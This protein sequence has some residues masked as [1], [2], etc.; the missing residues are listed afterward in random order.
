MPPWRLQKFLA[1]AGIAA[2]R[3]SEEIIKAGRV[4]VNGRVAHLGQSADPDKDKIELDGR[5]LKL[6][7]EYLYLM[8]NKPVGYLTTRYDPKGRPTVIDLLGPFK[9]KVYP[10]GRLD[11]DTSGL[12]L[13][14]NDGH[15]AAKFLQP[16]HGI[17]KEYLAEIEG[18]LNEK[19]C[20][21]LSGGMKLPDGYKIAP[22]RVSLESKPGSRPAIKADLKP[23]PKLGIRKDA[24]LSKVRI[25]LVQGHNRQIR[26]MFEAGGCRVKKLTRVRIGQLTLK[27]LA[28]GRWR[29]LTTEE[30]S[31]LA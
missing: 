5:P 23:R 8:L 25:E 4:K 7:Q 31:L 22:C 16:K 28:L 20:R 3:H 13:F 17:V 10:I 18:E 11:Y 21:K 6:P 9:T 12:L 24:S 27:N 19:I 2:R 26:Q 29:Q 1:H 15:F 14:T 30:M